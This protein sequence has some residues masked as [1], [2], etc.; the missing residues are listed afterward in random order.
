ME[1]MKYNRKNNKHFIKYLFTA[2]LITI[3]VLPACAEETL[4]KIDLDDAISLSLSNNLDL[5]SARI[6]VELAKN[7]IKTANRLQNPD[8]NIFYNYG[9]AG[10]SE[11]QQIGISELVEVAKRSPRKKLAKANLYKKELDVK[12]AEFTL[13]MD[14]RETYVDLVGAKSVLSCLNEQKMFLK[15]LL[16]VAKKRLKSGSGAEIDVIQIEIALNQIETRINSAKTVL[17]SARNDFNKTLNVGENSSVIYDTKEDMLPG[18]TVFISLKT[19]DYSLKMPPFELIAQKALEKRLDIKAAAQD[20]EIAKKNLTVVER[21]RIPDIEVSG[22]YAYL[23]KN[24]SDTGRYAPGAYAAANLQN[25]PL[26]YTYKPEIKNAKLQI[27]QTKIN[28]ES[29]R[30]KALKDLNSAYDRFLTSQ[31]NLIFYK[32]KLIKDS[33]NLMK[34]SKKNYYEGKSDLT[35]VL[36]MEQAYGEI[37]ISYLNS[38][39]DYYTDWIDFLRE[40]NSEEFVLDAENI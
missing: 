11:P 36:V 2:I 35:S 40:V 37:I 20:V 28:Y 22:G 26:L 13:E 4:K 17:R 1:K 19:P 29:A 8:I 18:E 5:Q 16:D 27:E 12:L 3:M 33:E 14:V 34:I 38:L 31:V 7:D 24:H 23:A 21:Q 25:I 39:T 30:N 6:D 10:R 9:S 32:Q 15:E